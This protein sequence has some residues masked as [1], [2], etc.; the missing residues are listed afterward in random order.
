MRV[1]VGRRWWN[2]AFRLVLAIGVLRLQ[3]SARERPLFRPLRRNR[4]PRGVLTPR[5]RRLRSG[6]RLLVF[7]DNILYRTLSLSL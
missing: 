6:V 4:G 3:Q 7:V 1:E 2:C 5:S